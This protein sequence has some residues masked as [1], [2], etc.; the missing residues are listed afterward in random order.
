MGSRA[1]SGGGK[2]DVD[3]DAL[4]GDLENM[5]DQLLSSFNISK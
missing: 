2:I 3:F 4:D 1:Y 5:V